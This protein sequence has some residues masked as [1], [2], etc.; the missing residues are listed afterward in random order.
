MEKEA[1]LYQTKDDLSIECNL[2]SHRCHI[3]PGKA[4][5]CLV[6]QNQRGKLITHSY[7]NLIAQ[8]ADP[9]EKKPLFHFLPGSRSWSIAS[10]GCNFRCQ[11]CQNWQISQLPRYS[12]LE[13]LIYI[14]PDQVVQDALMNDCK[15]IA[16]T[17]TEPTIFFEY[18]LDVARLAKNAGLKTIYVTNGY[19][20]TEMIDILAPWLDAA[21]VDIKAFSEEAYRRNIG[22]HLQPVLDA[23]V[24]LKSKDI[25][26]EITTLLVPGINDDLEELRLLAKYIANNLGVDTPWHISRYYPA[27]Q[28]MEV[29]ATSLEI[30]SAARQIGIDAGLR[31]VYSGNMGRDDDTIC[32]YCAEVAIRRAGNAVRHINLDDL[33][34]CLICGEKIAGIYI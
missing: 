22:A 12:T 30:I 10:P 21:N 29:P 9:I 27:Y 2:C 8:H 32:P 1:L 15:S 16:F 25:W 4:G 33:G 18:T 7:G 23:C 13:E 5:I 26:L 14:E 3:M 28:F 31:Y 34:R 19:M 17:Y 24:A 20:T 6:R 11:W